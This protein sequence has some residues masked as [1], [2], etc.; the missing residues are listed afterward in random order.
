MSV[1]TQLPSGLV[2]FLFTD[3]EGST[4]LAQRLGAGYR[5]VLH[6]HRRILR[7]TLA[8]DGVELFTEGDSF[9][10]A[11]ADAS[12]ALARC[13]AAQRAL[14]GWAST[15][16]R[17]RVRMGLHTGW[18]TPQ[19]GEY[20]SAEVHR[21]ARIAGAA[22]GGQVLC[23]LATARLADRLPEEV[24]LLDLGLFRL[25]GFDGREQL[26]QLVAPGLERAFPRPRT[27]AAPHNL[28]ACATSFVGRRC[29]RDRLAELLAE[30]RL[31]TVAG[32]GGAG[33]TRLAVTVA[34]DQVEAYRDGVWFLDLATITDPGLV[35][36]TLASTLGLR[37]EPGRPILDT[38]AEYLG[39]R[40]LLL[41]IDTCD[42]QV[43][44][45]ADLV[46]RLLVAA[47]GVRVLAT[48]R[49]PIGLPGELVW[50]IPALSLDRAADG[51]PGD[52]VALLVDR[53]TAARGGQPPAPAEL[54]YLERIAHRLGGLPLALELAAARLRVLAAH[55]LAERL[56]V[57]L[58]SGSADLLGTLDAG[59]GRGGGRHATLEDTVEWS[60]RTLDESTARLLR[61]LSVYATPV[62]LATA[63][64]L[65]DGDPLPAL[66]TLVDKSLLHAEPVVTGATYRMLD[67]IRSYAARALVAAGEER[68]ARD[69]HVAWLLHAMERAR[70]GP[71]GRAGTLSLYPLDRFADEVRAALRWCVTGGTVRPALR[72]IRGME[73]WWRER[74]LAREGR[75]WLFRLYGRIAETGEEVPPAELAAAYHVHSLH[76]GADGEFNEQLR[77][78]QRAEAAA[79]QAG[80]DGLLARVLAGRGPS[81]LDLGRDAEA[82]QVCREVIEWATKRGVVADALYAIFCLAQLLWRRRAFDE[83]AE[84]L[85]SARHAEAAR[86]DVRGRRSVDLLL[87]M[88]AL[89]RGDLVAGHDHVTVALRSRMEH[90]FHGRACEALNAMAVRCALGDDP[91]T[92]A[93]LFGAAAANRSRLRCHPGQFA[94]YWSEQQKAVRAALGDERF[95]AAYADGTRLSL[96]DAVAVALA[97]EHPDLS[98]G[99]AED[100]LLHR[101]TL[102][103]A[104]KPRSVLEPDR[105]TA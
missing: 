7:E 31:V 81:L 17:A 9:F 60:Y 54:P 93:R 4:R 46:A 45:V 28:P 70:L 83:A 73:Q 63:E 61:W 95:D 56:D 11:F 14:T 68:A 58:A 66:T 91:V 97:V 65:A 8:P 79:H 105:G 43:G 88:V 30:H 80:D 69:R 92:A 38:L 18:A 47:P 84:L 6:E 85:G 25:R 100:H 86:P 32:P 3:I 27:A 98:S 21:A 26:Y 20:A 77:F 78:S 62:D 76:A 49:E 33:K 10:F 99:Q 37:P 5:R 53:T 42:A 75:L 72:L 15:P 82:E 71:D 2:T 50:R 87:G 74:G 89:A 94:G 59:R 48:S 24:W 13:A 52:A 51:R 12:A 103:A 39:P 64:W 1:R 40:R 34:D 29:E 90:G 23:S 22:H 55:Q 16:E 36:V 101:V 96:V 35:A 41:V 102:P 19:G 44:A 104:R 67:P 57:E